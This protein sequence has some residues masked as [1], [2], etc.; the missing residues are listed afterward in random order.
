MNDPTAMDRD[1]LLAYALKQQPDAIAFCQSIM[2]VLHLWDDL[3][4]R[5]KPVTAKD[6]HL[7]FWTALIDLPRNRFYVG[8]FAEL[9]S[10]LMVAIQN[11]HAANAMERT[12][13]NDDLHIAFILRSSYADLVTLCALMVGG[14]EWAEYIT[15]I[16]RRR[17]HAEGFNGYCDALK[18][19]KETRLVL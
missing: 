12:E 6:I 11:W 5:D 4:D 3:V 10:A 19:E 17:W 13:F 2:R 15:P 8:N 1:T 18:I 9:N 16:L 14:H 7:G